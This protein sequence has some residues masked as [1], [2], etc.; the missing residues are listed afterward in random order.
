MDCVNCGDEIDA[1]TDTRYEQVTPVS[2]AG[3]TTDE[4]CSVGCLNEDVGFT[5]EEIESLMRE[6]G[7]DMPPEYDFDWVAHTNSNIDNAWRENSGREG[8]YFVLFESVDEDYDV[9]IFHDPQEQL[10][11][12]VLYTYDLD[13]NDEKIGLDEVK[14]QK[15]GVMQRAL[16]YAEGY[17]EVVDEG[18][19]D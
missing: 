1:S 10:Y 3:Q 14:Q 5:D 9:E 11:E 15:T 12:V 8:Q 4:F 19:M 6:N 17:M 16:S 13:N 2:G 18:L 7:Y